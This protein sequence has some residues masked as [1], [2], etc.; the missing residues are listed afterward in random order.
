MIE[1]INDFVEHHRDVKDNE[2]VTH[3]YWK[4]NIED[5]IMDRMEYIDVLDPE[6]EITCNITIDN[7][8]LQSGDHSVFYILE[9]DRISAQ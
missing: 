1:Y 5:F 2:A 8:P 3:Q 7:I 6:Y 9:I 4:K